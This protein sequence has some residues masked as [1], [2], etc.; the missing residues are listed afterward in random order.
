MTAIGHLPA[1]QYSAAFAASANGSSLAGINVD[2]AAFRASVFV[3]TTSTGMQDLIDLL[4]QSGVDLHRWELWSVDGFSADGHTLVGRATNPHGR[5]VGSLATL[6]EPA[7]GALAAIGTAL[8]AAARRGRSTV[9]AD[10][11]SRPRLRA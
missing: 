2:L 1:Y 8:L 3:W 7:T 11:A 9:K 10:R 4:A 5:T 6:P